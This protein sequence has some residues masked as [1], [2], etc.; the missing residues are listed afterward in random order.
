M[1]FPLSEALAAAMRAC[2]DLVGV[3]WVVLLALAVAAKIILFPL[4]LWSHANS[5]AMVRLMPQINRIKA[6]HFGDGEA[7]SEKQLELYRQNHY[8]P[9]LSLAP[10]AAQIAVL[11][12]A[13]GAV[14]SIAAQDD[15]GF[16]GS[17]PMRDGGGSWIMPPLAA[18]S[19]VA[20]GYS[21]NRINPLQREQGKRSQL[22][23]NGSSVAIS[24]ALG[25]F[26][27]AGLAFYWICSN[28]LSIVVQ[29][30]CNIVMD[31]RKTID[32]D[33]LEESKKEIA[34]LE[35]VGRTS[36]SRKRSLE[37][38]RR[39]K[40]DYERFFRVEGKHVVFYSERDGFYKYFQ[41]AIE[42]LL[43]NST[44][45]IH[46]ITSDPD[47][48][49][50]ELAKQRPRVIPYYIGERKLITLMMKLDADVVALTLYELGKH[51]L[52]RSLVRKDAEYIL[53]PHHATSMHMVSAEG[54]FDHYDAVLCVGPHQIEELRREEEL[55]ELPKKELV[56]CGYDLIDRQIESCAALGGAKSSPNRR[57]TALLAPSWQDDC[58]LDL[59]A[60]EVVE[61]L[62]EA[63]FRTIVRPH[64]EYTKRNAA[65]WDALVAQCRERFPEHLEFEDGFK[66]DDQGLGEADLLV[67]DWSSIAYEFSFST[68]RP[69]LFIDTP[70]KAKNPRWEDY[71][72]IPTD[73]SLRKETG[74]V[75]SLDDVGTAGAVALGM[76]DDAESW[77]KRI[78]ARRA[79]FFF[80]G[81][82]GGEA[83]GTYVLDRI[84]S[85]QDHAPK[86]GGCG[87]R[88]VRNQQRLPLAV[89]A[90]D[91]VFLLL[92]SSALS[93]AWTQPAYAYIDPSVASY[94]VQAVAGAAVALS[95]VVGTA[96]RATRKR[97]LGVLGLSEATRKQAEPPVRFVDRD[98][99]EGNETLLQ[100]DQDA[101][102]DAKRLRSPV[103]LQ[104]IPWRGRFLGM[105]APLLLAALTVCVSTPL[106]IVAKNPNEFLFLPTDA[107]PVLAAFALTV[108]VALSLALS[109][110][111]GKAYWI[112]LAIVSSAILSSY[113]AMS[114]LG[115]LAFPSRGEMD[116]SDYPWLLFVFDA[117]LYLAPF[118][119]LL[120]FFLRFRSKFAPITTLTAFA[121]VLAQT[122]GLAG[123]LV[124]LPEAG[125]S[126]ER[127]Y[128]T[129]DGLYTL[130]G[131]GDIVVFVL[132]MF[133]DNILDNAYDQA[134]APETLAEFSGFTRFDNVSQLASHTRTAIPSLLMGRPFLDLDSQSWSYQQISE[135]FAQRNLLDEL[136]EQGFSTGVYSAS[137]QTHLES[138]GS[139]AD[140][141]RPV[142]EQE[143]SVDWAGTVRSLTNL[144]L[145]RVLPLAFK[146]SLYEQTY[147]DEVNRSVLHGSTG[148]YLT[149]DYAYYRTLQE[150]GLSL[151]AE[152]K[153]FRFIHLHGAHWPYHLDKA[154]Q[155][156]D[157]E[158]DEPTQAL[159]SLEIVS[160]YLRQLKELGAYD[161]TTIIV[162]AD[163]G[164]VSDVLPPNER[165][166]PA[167]PI[168]LAKPATAGSEHS[169]LATSSD[170]VSH[171][172]IS[173]TIL[174]AAGG[175]GDQ[176][177]M[178]LFGERP[179][180]VDRKSYPMIVREETEIILEYTVVGDADDPKS[181]QATGRSWA[182]AGDSDQA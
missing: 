135:N 168:L 141:L 3:W 150:T 63:G 62:I 10:F 55:R 108:S 70:M 104:P 13:V 57:P 35:S 131:E 69:S 111:R 147:A 18:L 167:V 75:L 47:D 182:P 2:Y 56:A 71:G 74:R 1:G 120:L 43:D 169:P 121:L 122:V 9:L 109:L 178:P 28:L 160:E 38:A 113:F 128:L 67:T 85:K 78:E 137:L 23:A 152:K 30:L 31:P 136:Q 106:E 174:E 134:L 103:P 117:S 133:D 49:V 166:N 68:L 61:S 89:L 24:F 17:I 26:V 7:I 90:V 171:Q 98:D 42:W 12:V 21:Q 45:R 101:R 60:V 83:A 77:A 155:R 52:K 94:T 8:H 84:L 22:V 146:S 14:N 36:D 170:P 139:K 11:L 130:S 161:S 156:T 34:L 96:W 88:T 46:Y 181:W 107:L 114:Q 72:I 159:G 37:L 157:D 110:L 15:L 173:A 87:M 127:P 148:P 20:L 6:R 124:S 138:I 41:G 180:S 40:A 116:F 175:N 54:S 91:A 123:T 105:L 132:D 100:A 140:N 153:S 142:N 33:D 64:P 177:G 16:W 27:P 126:S 73:I 164:L 59:C 112:A 92:A 5:I 118:A 4:S 32:R 129:T 82:R 86:G 165:P 53:F 25:I 119:L 143:V 163:H 158:T 125:S 172:D 149:D 95:A 76:L 44:V 50:F 48:R 151:D 115:F 162:T 81:R 19:A 154:A 39:E 179:A 51:H 79:D 29:M 97:L 66:A 93:L 99:P 58:I 102:K 176:R 65:R 145:Y 144:G 80:N